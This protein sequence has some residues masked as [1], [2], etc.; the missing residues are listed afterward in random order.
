M[1]SIVVISNGSGSD[2][3]NCIDSIVSQNVADTEIVVIGNSVE[4]ENTGDNLRSLPHES[5]RV[6][7]YSLNTALKELTGD[8]ILFLYSHDTLDLNF[9]SQMLTKMEEGYDMVISNAKY[10]L[11]GVVY[12]DYRASAVV[13]GNNFDN[14]ISLNDIKARLWAVMYRRSVVEKYEIC[15]HETMFSGFGMRFFFDYMAQCNSAALVGNAVCFHVKRHPAPIRKYDEEKNCYE[16]LSRAIDSFCDKKN[17]RTVRA[18]SVINSIK[19]PYL[20]RMVDSLYEAQC[21]S[22][23]LRIKR[24]RNLNNDI[25]PLIPS[26]RSLWDKTLG[27]TLSHR[28]FVAYDTMRVLQRI[29]QNLHFF[30]K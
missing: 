4:L 11:D 30:H 15:F 25:V 9:L 27:F 29:L 13:H 26:G 7:Q 14:F 17:I 16:R 19:A 23:F 21:V 18:C 10:N 20:E 8:Y 28:M 1:I 12:K 2:L 5:G 22:F 24:L 3:Q 6:L